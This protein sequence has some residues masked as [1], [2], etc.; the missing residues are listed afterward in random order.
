MAGVWKR[1]EGSRGVTCVGPLRAWPF[2]VERRGEGF[3]LVYR[4][5]FS[6]L[7]DE[8]WAGAEGTWS[9]RTLLGDREIGRFRMRRMSRR[10]HSRR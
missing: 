1:I 9:G 6:A 5:P 7:V 10:D 2:G 3:A 8:V 4:P